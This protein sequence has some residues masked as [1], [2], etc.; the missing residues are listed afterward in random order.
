MLLDFCVCGKCRSNLRNRHA[1][2]TTQVSHLAPVRSSRR[3][4]QAFALH[5]SCF[6]DV[7]DLGHRG[8]QSV[9]TVCNAQASRGASKISFVGN[10]GRSMRE[11]ENQSRSTKQQR[12]GRYEERT[13]PKA[14]CFEF[15]V[16]HIANELQRSGFAMQLAEIW[17]S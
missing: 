15:G 16:L 13:S 2:A 12:T 17:F 8:T 11:P 7:Q 14:L 4:V 6:L 10:Q 3:L 5:N 1:K 9:L